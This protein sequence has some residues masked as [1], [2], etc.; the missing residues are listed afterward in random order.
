MILPYIGLSALLGFLPTLGLLFFTHSPI[1]LFLT[2]GGCFVLSFL[3][4]EGHNRSQGHKQIAASLE[5]VKQ[6][7]AQV[8]KKLTRI[9]QNQA[10]ESN[11][12]VLAGELRLL[13]DVI[14]TMTTQDLSKPGTTLEGSGGALPQGHG[15][16]EKGTQEGEGAP[17]EERMLMIAKEALREGRVEMLLQPIVSLPQR[18]PRA[19]ECYSRL[20]DKSGTVFTPNDYLKVAVEQD[21]IRIIDKTLLLRCM[22]MVQKAI[23]KKS[24]APF[25]CNLSLMTL[26]NEG[27]LR[28]LL[29]LIERNKSMLPVLVLE[30]NFQEFS[31]ADE[32]SLK[33]IRKLAFEGCR[34]SM[35]HIDCL[36]ALNFKQL[37]ALKVKYLKLDVQLLLA[38]LRQDSLGQ[39]ITALKEQADAMGLDIIVT[40]IEKEEELVEMLEFQFDF[41][42]GYL[43]GQPR[44]IERE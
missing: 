33:A 28:G 5:E 22:Q 26:K 12:D 30:L 18:K 25:F 2:W 41:G 40:K 10:Q 11:S 43:F 14:Q 42:Q 29:D 13:Q 20:R 34:F 8:E 17:S 21:L 6:A 9:E 37:K 4:C 24:A 32:A 35:D 27:F 7:Q 31:Q 1:T 44:L 19:F 3:I 36:D 15:A 23:R 38:S 39:T 16:A